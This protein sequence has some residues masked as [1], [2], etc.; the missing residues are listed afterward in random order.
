M[1]CHC[2]YCF[3]TVESFFVMCSPVCQSRSYNIIV[4]LNSKKNILFNL[5]SFNYSTCYLA[6]HFATLPE[7]IIMTSRKEA[8][9]SVILRPNNNSGKIFKH[10]SMSFE[11]PFL[12]YSY[13]KSF[14][15]NFTDWLFDNRLPD[16]KNA[17]SYNI[18]SNRIDV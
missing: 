8:F 1:F 14:H 12:S 4:L 9:Y 7:L 3:C 13:A 10:N 16:L 17:C 5:L 15:K 6:K 2:S 18:I 11:R